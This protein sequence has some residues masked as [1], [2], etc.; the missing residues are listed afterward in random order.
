MTKI[1][2]YH[3]LVTNVVAKFWR[4]LWEIKLKLSNHIMVI[5][6]VTNQWSKLGGR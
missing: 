6:S 1:C 3:N 2:D 5:I 4:E